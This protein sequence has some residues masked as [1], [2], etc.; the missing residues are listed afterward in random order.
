MSDGLTDKVKLQIEEILEKTEKPGI[1]VKALFDRVSE[2]VEERLPGFL[3]AIVAEALVEQI[4]KDGRDIRC[5]HFR[6]SY[7]KCEKGKMP[8][9]CLTCNDYEPVRRR[10]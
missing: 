3:A 9:A 2:V 6:G 7:V 4:A 5:K 1:D 8:D 10:K